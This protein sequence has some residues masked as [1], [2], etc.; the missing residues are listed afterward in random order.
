M[1][2]LFDQYIFLN[3]YT[4]FYHEKFHFSRLLFL[5]MRKFGTMLPSGRKMTSNI[6]PASF[7]GNRQ[8][9]T[10]VKSAFNYETKLAL[11]IQSKWC[12][13]MFIFNC[14]ST[15]LDLNACK[16]FNFRKH[17]DKKWLQAC[18]NENLKAS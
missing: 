17:D 10:L 5:L 18:S 13:Q 1:S 2:E 3:H 15:R 8:L 14:V 9:D 11:I 12:L 7:G 16:F 6:S 4:Y